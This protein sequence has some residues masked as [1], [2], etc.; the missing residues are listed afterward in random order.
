MSNAPTPSIYVACLASYNAGKLHGAWIDD[1]TDEDAMGEAITAMLAA[2][3]TP[4][5]EEWAIHDTHGFEGLDIGAH[6]TLASV[7]THASMLAEHD[8]AWRAYVGIVGAHYANES[9][10]GDTYQGQHDS[11]EDY[12]ESWHADRGTDLGTLA[13]YVDWARVARDMGFEGYAFVPDGCG[14]VYVFCPN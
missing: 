11:P 6:P 12:A 1:C 8:G 14:G 5:A 13:A 4:G 3:P 7:A 2:S 9:D 10:F